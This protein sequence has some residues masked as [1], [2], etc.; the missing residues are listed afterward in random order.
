MPGVL[1]LEPLIE[2]CKGLDV[3][4]LPRPCEAVLSHHGDA[5]MFGVGDALIGGEGMGQMKRH[6][7]PVAAHIDGYFNA[8]EQGKQIAILPPSI[9]KWMLCSDCA[10]EIV[11]GMRGVVKIQ[12][13]LDACDRRLAV[14]HLKSLMDA[15]C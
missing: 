5:Q 11:P 10:P 13:D 14:G 3:K 6:V 2:P 15:G 7:H 4:A 12:Q 1:P 8:I 9:A